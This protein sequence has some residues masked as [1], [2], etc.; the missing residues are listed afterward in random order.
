PPPQDA[1]HRPVADL[2]AA[3][4]A[5]GGDG[6]QT[7]PASGRSGPWL[8]LVLVATLAIRRRSLLALLAVCGLAG[9]DDAG[10]ATRVTYDRAV[11]AAPTDSGL[12]PRLHPPDAAH[13]RDAGAVDPPDDVDGAE[14]QAD[15]APETMV[16]ASWC[17]DTPE[18]DAEPPPDPGPARAA[19]VL[20]C[21]QPRFPAG[22]GLRRAPYLQRVTRTTASV[23]WTSTTGG[24]GRV[25]F[26]PSAAGPWIE[27]P[28][29]AEQFPVE[30][31]ADEVDYVQYA[32]DLS[33]LQPD[34][35]YCYAVLEDDQLLAGGL[36]F[37]TA[38]SDDHRPVRVLAF[39]DSGN[40]SVDQ[41]AVRDAFMQREFDLFLHLGDMAYNTGRFSEFESHVFGIY[42]ELL[43][44][45]PTFPA[46]GN[47]EYDTQQG[48]PYLDV[49]R[50]FEQAYR[51]QDQERYY[52]FDY[53]PVHFISLDSNPEMLVP[54][55]LD[56]LG[57][58]EDDMIDWLTDDLMASDATWKIAFFH[59]PPFSSS[60]R[61]FNTQVIDAILPALQRGGVDL[62]LV[63]HDHHYERTLPMRGRCPVPGGRGAIPY[64]IVGTAGAGLRAAPGGWWT[65]AVDDARHGFLSLTIQ[66]CRGVGE[67][68]DTEGEV[69]DRFVING[70]Q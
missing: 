3:S 21:G 19:P 62:V 56:P 32:V 29:E 38:W 20:D 60:Y 34:H 46:I 22:T 63:G 30:R 50:L 35:A 37:D 47:H 14:D 1:G 42:R 16:D 31:T 59:H 9:C 36:I 54:I 10:V 51:P 11:F 66:G 6:C 33:D 65:A 17:P 7:T 45:V 70:C 40:G 5:P 39:G 68:I 43:H 26:G 4:A 48:Q 53:G 69:F 25:R 23:V 2:G 67:A 41:I 8:L 57:R 52:S 13:P 58:H 24:M 18:V 64:V 28:A 27:V 49:Y 55:L 12:P 61:G 44:R 15:A